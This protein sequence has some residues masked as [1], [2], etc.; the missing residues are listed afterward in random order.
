MGFQFS[1][2][3]VLDHRKV[4]EEQIQRF[5]SQ[6]KGQLEAQ[7]KIQSEIQEDLKQRL[8]QVRTQQREGMDHPK[9][10]L[11]ETWIETRRM[12]I[13]QLN[14][15]IRKLGQIVEQWR[16]KLVRAMQARMILEEFHEQELKE[17]RTQEARAERKMF[18]E[19]GVRKYIDTQRQEKNAGQA[20]RIA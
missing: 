13:E 6:Y 7:Q 17:Y 5:Y 3:P 1:L 2:Q 12:D 18:D 20:E 11:Y 10:E 8:E 16:L 15:Q 14:E 9:R 19:I 4:Q